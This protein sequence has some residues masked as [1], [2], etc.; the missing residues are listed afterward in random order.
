MD[1]DNIGS[2]L[3]SLPTHLQIEILLSAGAWS[4]DVGVPV[5]WNEIVEVCE[6]EYNIIYDMDKLFEDI[7]STDGDP[8]NAF[9][10]I[11]STKWTRASIIYTPMSVCKSWM[12]AIKDS[13]HHTA[14]FMVNIASSDDARAHKMILDMESLCFAE[15]I[16]SDDDDD[17]YDDKP[18]GYRAHK[19]L[20]IMSL[21]ELS[22]DTPGS[23]ALI[24]AAEQGNNAIVREMLGVLKSTTADCQDCQGLICAVLGGYI[25]VVRTLLSWHENAALANCRDG[26][27]LILASSNGYDDIVQLLLEYPRNTA[28]A[29]SQDSKALLWTINN[30]YYYGRGIIRERRLA[31]DDN[32]V[33]ARINIIKKLLNHPN[34]SAHADCNN[35]EA[36]I[37]AVRFG[38]EIIV[39]MLLEHPQYTPLANCNDSYA[40]IQAAKYGH[41]E[42][43]QMLLDWPEHAPRA[44]C[45]NGEALAWAVINN[46]ESVV[47]ILLEYPKHAPR[48]N[49]QNGLA[50]RE[51]KK[52]GYDDIFKLL[53][54]F[55]QRD[56]LIAKQQRKANRHVGWQWWK[57]K[58]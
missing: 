39:R 15:C 34:H 40:L 46:H 43:V 53:V 1:I 8:Q 25:E 4:C 26:D 20:P 22:P 11:K 23:F 32:H 55:Q 14:R 41:T 33:E 52:K 49:C 35:N 2:L 45:D 19:D 7:W 57:K 54:S 48:A 51:A 9:Y 42:I 24:K 27:A 56:R 13:A 17:E 38:N 29:D 5:S 28:Y 10:V 21:N 58:K 37:Q 18:R 36:L 12:N 31:R 44:D 50:I 16:Y 47:R 30:H 3:Q 6:E